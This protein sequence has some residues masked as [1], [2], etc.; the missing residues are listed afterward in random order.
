MRFGALSSTAFHA[1]LVMIAL[2]G[3]PLPQKDDRFEEDVISLELVSESELQRMR[4]GETDGTKEE[5]PQ[6][7]QLN[8]ALFHLVGYPYRC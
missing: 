5:Q 4:Q 2:F 8:A 6:P 3:L 1:A 7:L